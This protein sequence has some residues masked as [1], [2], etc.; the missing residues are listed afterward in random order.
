M[1]I[2]KQ[3]WTA[4]LHA[5]NENLEKEDSHTVYGRSSQG[6]LGF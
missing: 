6:I 4:L 3:L 2:S 5:T 1:L